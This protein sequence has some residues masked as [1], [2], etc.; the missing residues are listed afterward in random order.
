MNSGGMVVVVGG[1]GGVTNKGNLWIENRETLWVL[2]KQR[3]TLSSLLIPCTL[4]GQ[5]LLV[6]KPV[7]G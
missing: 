7:Q 4:Y 6:F 2:R 3:L 1:G 5:I